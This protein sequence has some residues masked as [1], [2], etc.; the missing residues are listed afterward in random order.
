LVLHG[1]TRDS[2]ISLVKEKGIEID[3]RNTHIDEVIRGL[4]SGN[5]LEIF[6]SGTAV[7]IS[8]VNKLEFKGKIYPLNINK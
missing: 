3:E 2:V 1:V 6:C 7:T 5:L 8:S 4:E